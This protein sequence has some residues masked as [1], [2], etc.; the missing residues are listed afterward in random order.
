MPWWVSAAIVVGMVFSI[1]P[2][3]YARHLS[4][5]QTEGR[6]T[7]Y[8]GFANL[9]LVTTILK[10]HARRG[11]R[12]AGPACIVYCIGAATVPDVLIA[13]LVQDYAFR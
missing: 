7:W 11:D 8:S 5:G 2:Y 6:P 10:A 3:H 1:V 9:S 12:W 13:L 4:R